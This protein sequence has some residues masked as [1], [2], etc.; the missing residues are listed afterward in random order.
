M[1]RL[2]PLLDEALEREGAAREA[3]LER[4]AEDDAALA[5]SLRRMLAAGASDAWAAVVDRGPALGIAR[6]ADRSA[7]PAPGDCVGPYRRSGCSHRAAWATCGSPSATTAA[8]TDPWHWLPVLGR[9]RRGV[10]VQR[11]ERERAI[12]ESLS[13]PH[14]A[15][16]YDAGFAADGQPYLALEYVPGEPIDRYVEA[17]RLDARRLVLLMQQVLAAVQFAHANLVCIAT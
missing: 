10:L 14:I 6:A 13:H 4:L 2:A 5:Q 16:L 8:R 7:A 9:L 17:R 3:W 12:L 1:K 11:F 15:R